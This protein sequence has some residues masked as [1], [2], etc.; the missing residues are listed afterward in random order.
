MY[1]DFP[2]PG[3]VG[4]IYIA[5]DVDQIFVWNTESQSYVQQ[6]WDA[7]VIQQLQTNIA[8]AQMA[9]Q[10]LQNSK[11]DKP[12]LS[13]NNIPYW[14]QSGTFFNSNMSYINGNIGIGLPGA[15]TEKLEIGGRS[16]SD[17]Q[18]FNETSSAILPR[19]IKFKDGKFK[20]ALADGVEKSV[21]LE[22]DASDFE[23]LLGEYTYNGNQEIYWSSFDYSTSIGTTTTP[24]GLTIGQT[25]QGGIIVNCFKDFANLT[26]V[27]K[28]DTQ[29]R[30]I[31]WE[32]L[33]NFT[34]LFKVLSADTIQVIEWNG[35]VT[36]VNT[37]SANNLNNLNTVDWH[38]ERA[39]IG[40]PFFTVI[41]NLPLGTKSLR[42]EILYNAWTNFSP[43]SA[44]RF[45]VGYHNG[46]GGEV[47]VNVGGNLGYNPYN[48]FFGAGTS[49]GVNRTNILS[50][51]NIEIDGNDVMNIV[52][53][54][55][56][57]RHRA[58]GNNT[59]TNSFGQGVNG[60]VTGTNYGF[61]SLYFSSNYIANGSKF[62]VFKKL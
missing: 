45:R 5:L 38:L 1:S 16:K 46:S 27:G 9:F 21:L 54:S 56:W 35:G 53:T 51:I 7:Y 60:F 52:R 41:T 20:A 31:P 4:N 24:H 15:A 50:K 25:Y 14:H 58:S 39:P 36:T 57:V 43:Y 30:S 23:N 29:T 17:G 33:S 10:N 19:E 42:V 47:I 2:Q 40:S 62:R 44:D 11:L 59:F 48:I 3:E 22:G 34:V 26:D 61:F 32:Y 37:T 6:T 28:Y 55:G 12:N 18:V 8:S 49:S 13:I